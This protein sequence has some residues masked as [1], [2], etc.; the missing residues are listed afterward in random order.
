VTSA[1]VL[2][3]SSAMDLARRSARSGSE[4][5]SD[6]AT[7]LVGSD[8]SH[9]DLGQHRCPPGLV[10]NPAGGALGI[11]KEPGGATGVGRGQHHSHPGQGR[12][13]RSLVGNGVGEAL[14]IA[15]EPGGTIGAWLRGEW[16]PQDPSIADIRRPAS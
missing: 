11:S 16:S 3:N 4:A 12:C 8:Q 1:I 5:A 7:T 13:P 14:G 2:M 6:G 10:G 15:K 9:S